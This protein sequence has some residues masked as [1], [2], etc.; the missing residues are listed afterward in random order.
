[1][2]EPG[3]RV[4]TPQLSNE[5]LRARARRAAA[6]LVDP[7]FDGVLENDTARWLAQLIQTLAS[8]LPSKGRRR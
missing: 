6:R 5:D 8:R 2:A 7:K 3:A 1:M 4:P